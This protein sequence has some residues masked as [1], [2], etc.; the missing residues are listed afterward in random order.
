MNPENDYTIGEFMTRDIVEVTPGTTAM[1]C[2]EVMEAE[3]VSSVLVIEGNRLLG[4]ITEK[5]LARKVVGKGLDAKEVMAKDIMTKDL[6][7][8]APE[9]SLYDAMLMLGSRKIKHL[10]VVKDNIPLGMITAMDILR[11]QPS[12]MDILKAPKAGQE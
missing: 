12:Y 9:T 7:T 2:V 11:V 3:K 6:L 8:A 5:D 1:S 4:I 10:P